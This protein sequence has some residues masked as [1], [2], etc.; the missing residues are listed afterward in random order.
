M[1]IYWLIDRLKSIKLARLDDIVDRLHY[2]FTTALL[3]LFVFAVGLQQTFKEPMICRTTSDV[4][5]KSLKSLNN[6]SV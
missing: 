1:N 2:V 3:V 5:G 4:S 6:Q